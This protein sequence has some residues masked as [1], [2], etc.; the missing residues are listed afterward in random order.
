M[1][2]RNPYRGT[3]LRA[4]FRLRLIAADG[5]AS[6]LEVLADTG[7]PCALIVSPEQMRQCKRGDAPDVQTNFGTLEGG[8]LEVEIPEL[9]YCRNIVGFASDGV[10]HACQASHPDLAAL[11][12]LP[13][14]R[15]FEY[16]GDADSFWIRNV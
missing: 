6:E 3:P 12:G 15:E 4:W 11:A 16:G 13:L 2:Q 5:A 10:F 7:N 9:Q 1:E 14:L 8:W